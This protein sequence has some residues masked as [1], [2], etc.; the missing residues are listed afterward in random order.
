MAEEINADIFVTTSRRTPVLVENML[1]RE[2]KKHPRCQLFISAK[3]NNIPEAIG[4]ILGLSEVVVV[5]GDSISMISE[6]ASSG[7]KT[8]VFPVEGKFSFTSEKRSKHNRFIAMLNREGYILSSN[9]QGIRQATYDL[10]KNKI[11]IRILDDNGEIFEGV[12]KII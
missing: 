4:G 8:I 3:R 6:A 5:S 1:Q 7:K 10:V 11:Q 9:P 2:L 12:R